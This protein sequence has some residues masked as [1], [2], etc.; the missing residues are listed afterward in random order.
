MGPRRYRRKPA[1]LE[2]PILG[3]EGRRGSLGG[4][5]ILRRSMLTSTIATRTSV[6][7]GLHMS[8]AAWPGSKGNHR[9]CSRPGPDDPGGL[10]IALEAWCAS[11]SRPGKRSVG[12]GRASRWSRS[13]SGSASRD[14]VLSSVEVRRGTTGAARVRQ[15]SDSDYVGLRTDRT[16]RTY[17][18][19]QVAR[20]SS[21]TWN[22]RRAVPRREPRRADR[23]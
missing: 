19:S 12:E 3:R 14:P 11:A 8:M 16:S 20:W 10:V 17:G 7:L 1:V 6:W 5:L 15:L 21:S 2:E 9:G 18:L 13:T 4:V 23:R 22:K